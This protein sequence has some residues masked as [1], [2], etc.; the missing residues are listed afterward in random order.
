[1]EGFA[2]DG[3]A[4]LDRLLGLAEDSEGVTQTK[5]EIAV[6]GINGAME[7]LKATWDS[8]VSSL[9]ENGVVQN[10]IEWIT[11]IVNGLAQLA[12]EGNLLP[13]IF[14]TI[15]AAMTLMIGKTIALAAAQ[16]WLQGSMKGAA[17]LMLA[18]TGVALM[19]VGMAG[20]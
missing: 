3:G 7:E 8:L 11:D 15:S 17:G 4:E 16:M 1:M 12:K 9:V 5:Y 2:E 14:K 18:G 20:I 13:A 6:S 19:T 10:G